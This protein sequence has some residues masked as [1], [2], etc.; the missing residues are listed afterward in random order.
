MMKDKEI[1]KCSGCQHCSGLRPIGNTRTSFTCS[2]AAHSDKK[3]Q[4]K[5]RKGSVTFTVIGDTYSVKRRFYFWFHGE[6]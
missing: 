6:K 3:R 5:N 4:K 2:P 1:I